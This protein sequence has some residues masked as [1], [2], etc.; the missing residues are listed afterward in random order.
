[1]SA[2]PAAVSTV[3]NFLRQKMP[4]YR[5]A[6]AADYSPVLGA[7][8]RG[9]AV[10]Q[11]D[12]NQDKM[13][14]YAVLLVNDQDKEN[15]IYYLLGRRSG[16]ETVLLWAGKWHDQTRPVR[17]PVFFKPAGDPGMSERTYNTLTNDSDRPATMSAQERR[18]IHALKAAPYLAVPAIEVWTGAGQPSSHADSLSELAYC[19]KTWYY[20][21]GVLK[22]F[23]A[24]D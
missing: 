9:E 16:L 12:F 8:D 18:E 1:M 17:N 22:A 23:E 13:L 14:D 24:C 4:A 19:S 7:E 6:T 11:A 15:R 10:I 20:Q 3:E 5:L 2:S 21:G